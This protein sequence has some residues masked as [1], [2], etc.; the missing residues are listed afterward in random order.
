LRGTPFDLFGRT[1][2]RCTERQ[3]I[4]DYQ[5][6]IDEILSRLDRQNHSTAVAIASI[7]EEIRGFGHVKLRHL[8]AAKAKE[9]ELLAAFRSPQADAKVA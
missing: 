3:L 8:K 6:T 9:A 4:V 1:A 2:E 7:P 5:R